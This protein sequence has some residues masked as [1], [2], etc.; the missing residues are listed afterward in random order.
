MGF[1]FFFPISQKIHLDVNEFLSI[2][3]R[4]L[5]TKVFLLAEIN[6]SIKCAFIYSFKCP[7]FLF[8][9]DV[10]S[11]TLTMAQNAVSRERPLLFLLSKRKGI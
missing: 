3:L 9:K 4:I 6:E 8:K 1:F 7:F 11:G 5:S 10:R 2:V